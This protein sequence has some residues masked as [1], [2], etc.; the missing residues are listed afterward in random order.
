MPQP[1]RLPLFIAASIALVYAS[2]KHAGGPAEAD[3]Q[4]RDTRTGFGYRRD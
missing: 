2:R 3:R 4:Q 1:F